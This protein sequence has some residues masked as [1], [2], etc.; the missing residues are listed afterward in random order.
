MRW[1]SYVG[2][3]A[4]THDVSTMCQD[5]N[6][7][8]LEADS[9]DPAV[10]VCHHHTPVIGYFCKL[11]HLA[12]LS[13]SIK[14]WPMTPS[15]FCHRCGID[16]WGQWRRMRR[17]RCWV[18][19]QCNYILGRATNLGRFQ[20]ISVRMPFCHDSNHRALVT[21]ICAGGKKEM[22]KYWRQY[23]CF[24]LRIPQGPCTELESMYEELH[25]D[26]IPPPAMQHPANR[27]ILDMS[28]NVID[29]Q[30]TLRRMGN[31]PL[32]IALWMGHKI[33]SSLAADC[34]QRA[35]NAAS[36]IESHLSNGALK[37]VWHALKGWYRVVEDCPA[38]ACPKMMEKQPAKCVELYAWAPPMEVALPF[39]F[40]H[41]T[42][43]DGVPTNKKIRAVVSGLK[44]G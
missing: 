2:M 14:P 12:I 23:W 43:P 33:K 38:P 13:N 21:K 22:T 42:I 36:F 9:K 19:S 5:P 26:V 16:S 6:L 4:L 8:L 28:W 10:P 24:L 31:L 11:R 41:F 35:A 25:L 44:D 29:K 18:S 39:N 17:G 1:L 30:A 15:C 34:T 37:K 27:W 20:H 32:T 7:F 3:P 40:P